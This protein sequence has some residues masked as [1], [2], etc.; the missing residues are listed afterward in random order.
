M[1]LSTRK[2]S[3][4]VA[5]FATTG[6]KPI[7]VE[8][9]LLNPEGGGECTLADGTQ[10]SKPSV[11]LENYVCSNPEDFAKLVKACKKQ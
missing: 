1:T 8:I 6:C 7:K 3:L 5:F 4:L 2:L 11:E 10:V 9:C